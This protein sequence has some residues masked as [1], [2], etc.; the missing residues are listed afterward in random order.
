MLWGLELEL[1]V[2][3]GDVQISRFSNQP[4]VHWAASQLWSPGLKFDSRSNVANFVGGNIS[5][6]S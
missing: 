1:F 4:G 5:C 2:E 6:N 3:V